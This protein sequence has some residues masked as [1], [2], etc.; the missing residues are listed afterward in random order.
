MGSKDAVDQA[1]KATTGVASLPEVRAIEAARKAGQMVEHAQLEEASRLLAKDLASAGSP[2][3]RTH[4]TQLYLECKSPEEQ[5]HVVGSLLTPEYRELLSELLADPSERNLLRTRLSETEREH[6]L[7]IAE[8]GDEV[9]RTE[10]I[11][12]LASGGPPGP[13]TD[14]PPGVA[15]SA[16]EPD[17][18]R[19]PGVSS[20]SLITALRRN[21]WPGVQRLVGDNTDAAVERIV[22]AVRFDEL[23]HGELR[24]LRTKSQEVRE[25]AERALHLLAD[26]RGPQSGAGSPGGGQQVQARPTMPRDRASIRTLLK[27]SGPMISAMGAT[28]AGDP[29]TAPI[30]IGQWVAEKA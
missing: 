22:A 28:Y 8:I 27:Q 2:E 9:R 3:L 5:A 15:V 6:L 20:D 1:R 7:A 25:L 19:R 16:P 13:P 11:F 14:P 10:V 30:L 29:S 12:Q 4:L 24:K 17:G 26:E 21:D 23:S 18:D